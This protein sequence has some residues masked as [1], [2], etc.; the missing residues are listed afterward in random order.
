VNQEP[1]R[2][3]VPAL[4][5]QGLVVFRE[6]QGTEHRY[7]VRDN[8]KGITY[9]FE[10]WQFFVLEVL[11]GCDD[12]AKLASVF[13]DRFGHSITNE[14]VEG[15]FSL[16]ADMKL[17]GV[18]AESHPL[19][20]A[21]IKKRG[22]QLPGTSSQRSEAGS[23]RSA[24]G[25]TPSDSAA[26]KKEGPLPVFSATVSDSADFNVHEFKNQKKDIQKLCQ[27]IRNDRYE[28]GTIKASEN[29]IEWLNTILQITGFF[30]HVMARKTTLV[31]TDEIK[32]LRDATQQNRKK[33]F[34]Q[35]SDVEK[36]E[37]KRLN[38]AIIELA[39]PKEAPQSPVIDRPVG[40]KGWDLFD[41]T[42]LI[43]RL[44]PVLSPVK[45]VVYALPPMLIVTLM[46][47]IRNHDMLAQDTDF[48]YLGLEYISVN[49]LSHTL[50]GLM[51]D[52]LL[53]TITFALVAYSYRV[54]VNAFF[55]QLHFGFFPRFH[56]RLGNTD[57]LSRREKLWLHASPILVRL[58][59]IAVCIF[60]W[61]GTRGS[62]GLVS[63]LAL[64]LGAI[65]T[66]SLFLVAN[67]LMKSN[68]YNFLAAYMNEP[69]LKAKMLLAITN[70]IKGNRYEKGDNN[71]LAAYGLASSLFMFLTF[72]VFLSLFGAYLKL[73]MGGAGVFLIVLLVLLWILRLSAKLKRIN[74]TYE[75][76]VQFE[77]W[78]NI[79]LPKVT[80]DLTKTESKSSRLTYLYVSV[81][82]L[83]V[84][85]L[86]VPYRYEPGGYFVILPNQRAELTSGNSDIIREIYFDGGEILQKGTVLARL[87]DSEYQSQLKI[88]TAKMKEQEAI[89]ADLRSRP[90]PEEVALAERELDVQIERSVYSGEK[91]KRYERL[92]QEKTISFAELEDQRR[93]HAVDLEQN[94]QARAALEL[95]KTGATA[96]QIAAAEAKLQSY[97]EEC[98][99]YRQ[100]V[101]QSIIRMP[102]DGKLEGI[103]LKQ[104]MGHYL[105]KGEPF[106][107]AVNIFQVFAQID[108][109]E[110]DVRYVTENSATR[111]RPST[112]SSEDF[113][114]SVAVIDSIVTP[115]RAGNI[116][117]V[118][119][120]LQNKDG[121]LKPGMTGYAKISS[122]SMPAWKVLSLA[123]IR[124]FEVD[125]WS[126]V[127]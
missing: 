101:D 6:A 31:L 99:Y 39:Y 46:I 77:R 73:H 120:V 62:G 106:A 86:V 44:Y 79:A 52:N 2:M 15:L 121:R 104:K 54:K 115:Q 123:A 125:V 38:R 50:F 55:L 116:V 94:K 45:Y 81:V 8:W 28:L 17:F 23:D 82:F 87:D 33:A 117:K 37:I 12:F 25:T 124:F 76:A 11:P 102:F 5:R 43:K 122:A 20:A 57:Q 68:A 61:Y 13:K 51:T 111:I 89:V 85:G 107:F 119:T 7:K 105:N 65:T 74:E 118:L 110:P 53:A 78:R 67:P 72:L 92:F 69:A 22:I 14:E 98:N 29:S 59:S 88:Y 9:Q 40:K 19:V 91:L 16:V 24:V 41:P 75:N 35:I 71:V 42:P 26:Q 48:Y 112:Y 96:E 58:G 126:W 97:I 90:K 3:A 83:I 4:L 108:V 63:S 109:P 60:L 66:A 70:K 21:F 49:W 103:N 10:P 27:A 100:K 95:V 84:I 127:P 1:Q 18:S 80:D 93:E 36:N 34:S 56:V 47:V 64:A 30:D 113:P 114:G 32:K